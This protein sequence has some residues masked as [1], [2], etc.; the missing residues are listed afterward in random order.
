MLSSTTATAAVVLDLREAVVGRGRGLGLGLSLGL[1]GVVS[2]AL[3]AGDRCRGV[4]S[5][6]LSR[7]ARDDLEGLSQ[8]L[9]LTTG[10]LVPLC[11]RSSVGGLR[12]N[13][14]RRRYR[15]WLSF[16]SANGR[17]SSVELCQACVCNDGVRDG[18][19]DLG[20]GSGGLSLRNVVDPGLLCGERSLL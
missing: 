12:L 15:R 13:A 7:V 11:S 18:L 14:C 4:R 8:R 20:L 2:P 5:L 3:G 1:R 9:V 17:C 16:G 6:S 19:W 10:L